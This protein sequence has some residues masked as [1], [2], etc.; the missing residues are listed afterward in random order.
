MMGTVRQFGELVHFSDAPDTAERPPPH[1]GEHTR[2][3][4]AEF[5]YSPEEIGALLDKGSVAAGA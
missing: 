3:I 1:V 2:E 5:G 4:L